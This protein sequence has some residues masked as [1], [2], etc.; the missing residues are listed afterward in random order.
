MKKRV[1][2]MCSFE[3]DFIELFILEDDEVISEDYSSGEKWGGYPKVTYRDL[4]GN[5]DTFYFL[6]VVEVD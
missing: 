5:E 4:D 1:Y 6:E 2:S 3:G